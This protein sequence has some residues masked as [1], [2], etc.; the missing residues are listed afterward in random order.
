MSWRTKKRIKITLFFVL[1]ILIF[2]LF[3][4]LI[5]KE[6]PSCFDGVQNQG[7][8]GV[9]CG[10]PCPPCRIFELKEPK[11]ELIKKFD[12]RG[13]LD[14]LIV[15]LNQNYDYGLLDFKVKIKIKKE[16]VVLLEKEKNVF[17]NPG[18]RKYIIFENLPLKYINYDLDI[19]TEKGDWIRPKISPD[20][21]EID[22]QNVK[23]TK[24]ENF[25]ILSGN[26]LNKRN[27]TL[28]NV[29]I[30]GLLLSDYDEI[31]NINSFNLGSLGPLEIKEFKILFKI[32]PTPH[33]KFKLIP[34]V[35]LFY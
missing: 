33:S 13:V 5:T 25:Y 4:A 32:Q 3:L 15:V 6:K 16:N 9:D 1:I 10:G 17:I 20:K 11:I 24:D 27:L 14:I 21:V 26:V 12:F 7:E 23:I 2:V 31:L 29:K 22:F 30:F 34:D 28:N 8:L 19:E 35:N 18:Q